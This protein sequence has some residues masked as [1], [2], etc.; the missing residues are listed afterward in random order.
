MLLTKY[1]DYLLAPLHKDL[2]GFTRPCTAT[3]IPA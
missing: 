1:S 3:K 2:E